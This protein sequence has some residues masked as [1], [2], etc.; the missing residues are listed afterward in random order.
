MFTVSLSGWP[1][2][3]SFL[4]RFRLDA[5]V[6]LVAGN[7]LPFNFAFQQ[8]LDIVQQLLLIHTDQR[9]GMAVTIPLPWDRSCGRIETVE[10]VGVGT[11]AGVVQW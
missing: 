4:H 2:R 11:F 5:R 10:S 9:Y 1:L 6:R 8:A 7:D 3:M